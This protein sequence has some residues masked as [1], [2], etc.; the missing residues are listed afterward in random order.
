MTHTLS[1]RQVCAFAFVAFSAPAVTVCASLP[2]TWVLP[3]S[4]ASAALAALAVR[5]WRNSGASSLAAAI[6]ELRGGAA[7][8]VLTALFAVLV[9]HRFGR[10]AL[11]AFPDDPPTAFLP[12]TLLAVC[13]WA[14]AK[15]RAAVLRAVGVASFF[16]L[17]AYAAIA[18]FALPDIE[19]MRLYAVRGG[20]PW[21]L[22]VLLTPLFALFL[23]HR[24]DRKVRSVWRWTPLFVLFPTASALLC[25]LVPGAD[26]SFYTMAKSVEVLSVAQ[27]VEPLVSAVM[28]VG[29][30]AA[31]CLT[32]LT[33]GEIGGTLGG[34]RRKAAV[35]A[36]AAAATC[37]F[38]DLPFSPTCYSAGTIILLVVVPLSALLFSAKKVQKKSKQTIDK[39]VSF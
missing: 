17:G 14:C 38:G 18:A 5:L 39:T 8:L 10:M 6:R 20:D 24:E 2:W 25:A 7:L 37:V 23:V 3:A 16:V 12:L 4:T 11:G 1:T 9:M 33:V 22:G 36:V 19:P 26:G 32:A 28:T 29:W 35:C 34:D 13:A 21:R 27:R 15:S 30:F 31:V